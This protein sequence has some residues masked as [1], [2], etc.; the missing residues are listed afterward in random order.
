MPLVFKH[1]QVLYCTESNTCLTNTHGIL[2]LNFRRL[3]QGAQQVEH[4]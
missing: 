4:N 3:Q 1:L 2:D